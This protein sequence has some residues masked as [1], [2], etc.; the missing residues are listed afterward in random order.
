[1]P[2]SKRIEFRIGVHL[3]DVVEED[4]GDLMGDG[5][6]IAA[7][8]EGVAKP[9]AICLSED[10]YRQVKSRLDIERQRSRPA[11]ALKNIAEPV[12][13]YSVEV[14]KPGERAKAGAGG[15][16]PARAG[17]RRRSR[18]S[19]SLAGA[20][21]AWYL[22]AGRPAATGVGPRGPFRRADRRDP[23]VRQRDRRPSIRHARPSASAR[24]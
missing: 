11:T 5:V 19:W 6:N 13:V 3:G 18:R 17:R 2:R 1:M 14:G 16:R 24:R 12:R 4:D 20:A 10:A 7:R 8:L 22:E 15:A 23:A 21:G 9:G